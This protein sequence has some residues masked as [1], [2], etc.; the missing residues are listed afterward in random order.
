MIIAYFP[1]FFSIYFFTRA[2]IY[3]FQATTQGKINRHVPTSR[4][5][6]TE[7]RHKVRRKPRVTSSSNSPLRET[8]MGINEKSTHKNHKKSH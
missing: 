3:H 6:H 7:L 5:V 1:P 4:A 2:V 8:E